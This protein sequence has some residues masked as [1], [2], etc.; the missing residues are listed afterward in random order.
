MCYS[1]SCQYCHL[2]LKGKQRGETRFL[3]CEK[4][5]LLSIPINMI[6]NCIYMLYFFSIHIFVTILQQFVEMYCFFMFWSNCWLIM[7]GFV[8]MCFMNVG[9]SFGHSACVC[10]IFSICYSFNWLKKVHYWPYT[11]NFNILQLKFT[12]IFAYWINAFWHKVIWTIHYLLSA[13]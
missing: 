3:S 11:L 9:E 4:W 6:R 1:I 10:I 8:W 13:L 2:I 12:I 7:G 5:V